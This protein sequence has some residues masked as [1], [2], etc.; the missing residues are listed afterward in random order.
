MAFYKAVIPNDR[1]NMLI[2][3]DFTDKDEA[4]SKF[5]IIFLRKKAMKIGKPLRLIVKIKKLRGYC[6][7]LAR[8]SREKSG[9]F[10]GLLLGCWKPMGFIFY[11]LLFNIR[12]YCYI[13][14]F[15]KRR[16]R[17]LSGIL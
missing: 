10:P 5:P 3:C 15:L 16:Y 7:K 13:T 2:K 11:C 6:R 8:F 14:G 17:K 4:S 9:K 12:G 1:W